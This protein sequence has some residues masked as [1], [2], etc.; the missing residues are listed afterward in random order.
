MTKALQIKNF[1][2]Y[3]ITE[4]GD[5]YSRKN[6]NNPK[7]RIKKLH[8]IKARN[9]YMRVW[10][11]TPKHISF[12]VHRL[13]A[14]TFIPNPD[15]KPQVNHKN[16]IKTDNRVENL[17]W[18]TNQENVLH[19]FRILHRNKKG[20]IRPVQQILDN[21]II[22]EFSSVGEAHR[23]TG[24]NHDS[25]YKSCKNKNGYNLAGGFHWQYK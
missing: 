6:T 8:L 22:A 21:K 5:I 3:Y 23:K 25:I 1:P 13:V 19:S 24:I 12:M 2:E 15:N 4:N 17:E 11:R 14:Q 20:I 16:G 10:F 7:G 9:G 18:V